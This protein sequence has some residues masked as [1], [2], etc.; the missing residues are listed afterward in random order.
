MDNFKYKIGKDLREIPENLEEFKKGISIIE[1]E[2]E[3]IQ[4]RKV[5]AQKLSKLGVLYR[6]IG[7][8]NTSQNKLLEASKLKNS[9]NLAIYS[10]RNE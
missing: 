8:L 3:A 5:K 6:I 10:L 2:V 4:D 7:E 9:I 1:K